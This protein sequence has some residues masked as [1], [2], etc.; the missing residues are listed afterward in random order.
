VAEQRLHVET[1]VS[2][3]FD[4]NCQ[5]VWLEGRTDCLVIDPGFDTIQ[6]LA[7]LDARGLTP[8]AILITHGH[9]DHIG[10][11]AALKQ[12]W[13]QV[14]IVVGEHEAD[15]LIDPAGN[16]SATYGLAL[17]SPPADTLVKHGQTIEAAGMKLE[18]REIPG[19]SS[20]HVVYVLHDPSPC[21]VFG[22]DV[23]FAGSVGR[24][25]FP[26]G[27]F[28]QLGHGIHEH[29]FTLPDDTVVFAGH[30]P[31]TTIGAEKR[32]NPFVGAPAGWRPG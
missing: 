26:G 23:L 4:Q 14:P 2:A 21:H 6:L 8:A 24:T 28:P 22:G 1:V 19:H 15:K 17:V 3:P 25:D 27:S 18:T 31:Q 13:P 5:V 7:L 9:L 12:R 16:L 32:S 29:L 30:G 20:G 11:N 10:G